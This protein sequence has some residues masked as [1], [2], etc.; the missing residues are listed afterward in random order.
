M[1]MKIQVVILNHIT[2]WH[3]NP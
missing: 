1:V 2:T 3:H